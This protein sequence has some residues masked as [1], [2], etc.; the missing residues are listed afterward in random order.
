MGWIQGLIWYGLEGPL[1]IS[2]NAERVSLLKYL[3]MKW[4][5]NQILPSKAGLGKLR[6]ATRLGTARESLQQIEKKINK[7]CKSQSQV[8]RKTIPLNCLCWIMNVFVFI[9]HAFY[10]LHY[11]RVH[12]SML[13]GVA[14]WSFM[15]HWCG[16]HPEKFA[17][18]WSKACSL[19][20]T[21][22]YRETS[23]CFGQ[24]HCCNIA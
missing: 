10:I 8:T 3:K 11:L 12:H 15:A 24:K 16:P 14:L 4:K 18:H 20:F 22:Y 5:W 17:H 9:N 7:F 13:I 6:P 1:K 19:V 21:G 2:F 23:R